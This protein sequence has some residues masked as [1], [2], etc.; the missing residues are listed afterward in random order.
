LGI[1][2]KDYVLDRWVYYATERRKRPMEFKKT[3]HIKES[4]VC[5]F[6]HGNEHLTPPEIGRI[7]EEDKWK[8]RWFPNKFPAVELKGDPKI[9]KNKFLTYSSAYGVHEV[10]AETRFHKK[11]L[12]DLSVDHIKDILKI[13]THRIEVL[14]KLKNIRYVSVFKNHGVFAGT[15]LVHSHTQVAAIS[16]L[17]KEVMDKVNAAK[18]H[19][20]CPYCDIIKIERKTKRKI[21]ENKN[22]IAFAPFASRFNFEVSIFPK[23]H[24]KNIIDFDDK[25]LEDLAKILKKILL[26]LKKSNSSYNYYLHYAPKGHDLHFHIELTPRFAKWGG[27]ELSTGA[28]INSVMP[29]DAAKFYKSK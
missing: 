20:G 27:F 28:I 25:E 9:R 3:E 24:R 11:Q 5:F 23:K 2:R 29:E 1:L 21:F 18:K 15:S 6:C 22:I 10:I 19:S 26:K 13:Y 7:P 12:A 8:I 16:M 4:R 14:S 17:P